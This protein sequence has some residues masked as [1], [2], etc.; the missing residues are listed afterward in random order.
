M[1]CGSKNLD[2]KLELASCCWV[3]YF[4][5]LDTQLSAVAYWCL[6]QKM[7]DDDPTFISRIIRG[8]ERWVY[9]Y[10]LETNQQSLHSGRIHRHEK[11][12][13]LESLASLKQHAHRVFVTSRTLFTENVFL[14]AL[15]EFWL[16]LQWFSVWEMCYKKDQNYENKYHHWN[17]LAHISLR[18]TQFFT[19][20]SM[21]ITPYPLYSPDLDP[22]D[23]IL[24][25]K[26]NKAAALTSYR[27]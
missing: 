9:S 16:L 7:D 3:I 5:A 27:T 1:R 14:L 22:C 11:H 8:D 19:R 23:F 2:G 15:G 26:M 13:F 10:G 21:V 17:A 25:S 20:N 18:M 4:S 6:L 12:T 24:F